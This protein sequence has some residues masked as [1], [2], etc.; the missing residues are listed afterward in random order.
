MTAKV[1]FFNEEGEFIREKNLNFV[2]RP[3]EK[4]NIENNGLIYE[5]IGIRHIEHE[6]YPHTI[7]I[8]CKKTK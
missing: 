4:E 5:V 3:M 6:S 8:E 2:C 7:L 1:R